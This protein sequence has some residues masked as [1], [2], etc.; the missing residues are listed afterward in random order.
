MIRS[1]GRVDQFQGSRRK[2]DNPREYTDDCEE[3]VTDSGVQL[4]VLDEVTQERGRFDVRRRGHVFGVRGWICEDLD[5]LE[6]E[7]SLR[8]AV[9]GRGRRGGWEEGVDARVSERD[10]VGELL[11]S[12]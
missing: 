4:A 12:E 11:A 3:G 1:N 7:G 8:E 2:R 10:G 6:K 9:C 5:D